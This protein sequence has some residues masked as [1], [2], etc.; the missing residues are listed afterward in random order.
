M[1]AYLVMLRHANDDLPLL[2][3]PDFEEA[4]AFA[5]NVTE[6]DGAN[7][8]Q[9]LKLDAN[10]PIAVHVYDFR[11]GRLTRVLRVKDFT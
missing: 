8:K 1:N 6:E 7:E 4:K 10:T 9:I 5:K 11:D 2:L 3:T